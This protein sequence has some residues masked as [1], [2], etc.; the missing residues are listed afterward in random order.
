MSNA[1]NEIEAAIAAIDK[2]LNTIR[3]P[4]LSDQFDE[5][6]RRFRGKLVAM[7]TGTHD[8]ADRS[9]SRAIADGWPFTSRLGELI[10]KAE[11][12]YGC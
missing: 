9:M 3:E 11:Q 4:G 12:K 7:Q 8:Q 1:L 6:I 10:V 5:Q 2:H